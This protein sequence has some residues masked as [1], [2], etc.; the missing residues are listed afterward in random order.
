MTWRREAFWISATYAV[1]VLVLA[2]GNAYLL[3]SSMLA[4]LAACL[5]YSLPEDE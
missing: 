3:M 5:F 4:G 2:H 1:V